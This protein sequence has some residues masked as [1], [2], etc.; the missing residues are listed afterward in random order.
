M[1]KPV[2]ILTSGTR[3]DVLPYLALGRALQGR[4]LPVRLAAHRP[5][6]AL[7]QQAGL[8]Y[9]PLGGNPSDLLM[10]PGDMPLTA[11]S[12]LWRGLRASLGFWRAARPLYLDLLESAWQACQGASGVIVGLPTTWGQSIAEAL[13][14]PCAWCLLQP[15][16]PTRTFPTVFSPWRRS[17]G[18]AANLFTH[19]LAELSLWLPWRAETNAWRRGRL[20]LG[21]L[22]RRGPFEALYA[23]QGPLLYGISPQVVAPPADWP[24]WSRLTGYWFAEQTTP[25]QPPPALLKFLEA[26]DP[27]LYVGFGSMQQT[28]G[29]SAMLV[30]AAK[31]LQGPGGVRLAANLG[32][33]PAD[34]LPP[35]L[36]LLG[37]TPHDW[38]F[39]HLAGALHHGGAG[40]TAASLRAGLPT[41]I[42]PVGVDQYFWGERAAALGVGPRPIP[43]HTLTIPRLAALFDALA[44]DRAMRQRAQLLGLSIRMEDGANQAASLLAPLFQPA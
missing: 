35:N 24:A 28:P 8:D 31:E 21:S 6:Q 15:L 25:W 3:G 29:L 39:A 36:Y 22:P 10:R 26:G 23:R 4:G 19:R 18:G 30:A 41:A 42:A 40:T 32:E 14:V 33:A 1:P 27:P 12:G 5:F 38:L 43:Q 16:S 2:V 20:E 11:A 17:F 9:A 34:P 37:E 13:G 44:H 7:V